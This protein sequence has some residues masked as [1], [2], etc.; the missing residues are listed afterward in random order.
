MNEEP[1]VPEGSMSMTQAELE[2]MTD[3]RA[4]KTFVN[5][6]ETR[7]YGYPNKKDT[8]KQ[9]PIRNTDPVKK[10]KK[11]AVKKTGT[12][13]EFVADRVFI[14]E[15]TPELLTEIEQKADEGTLKKIIINTKITA[16]EHNFLNN[17]RT[18]KGLQITLG[19][20]G[21]IIR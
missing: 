15:M 11:V 21:G 9:Q 18:K 17:I 13:N 2:A 12:P 7:E 5:Q 4:N 1:T 16:S 19:I 8:P 6:V 14:N 20:K 3:G 10:Q